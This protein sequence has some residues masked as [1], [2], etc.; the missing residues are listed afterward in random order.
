MHWHRDV[1]VWRS[2]AYLLHEHHVGLGRGWEGGWPPPSHGCPCRS[3]PQAPHGRTSFKHHKIYNTQWW[4]EKVR[5]NKMVDNSSQVD[6]WR[7]V[8]SRPGRTIEALSDGCHKPPPVS[9]QLQSLGQFAQFFNSL[10]FFA[11]SRFVYNA[12]EA[13]S[14]TK[15]EPLKSRVMLIQIQKCYINGLVKSYKNLFL[16]FQ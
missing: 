6:V 1:P 10:Y 16:L 9:V 5:K 7:D 3:P 2:L 15:R 14:S 11:I 8:S 13:A 4:N 12:S